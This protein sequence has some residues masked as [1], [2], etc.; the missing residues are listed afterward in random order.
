LKAGQIL[1]QFTAQDGKKVMLRTPKWE[2]LDDLLKVSNSLV[3]EEAEIEYDTQTTRNAEADWLANTLA[4]L[5]KDR[6]LSL[7][8]EVEGKVVASSSLIKSLLSS[9]KHLG[10]IGIII[11]AGYRNIGIGTEMMKMLI[12]PAKMRGLKI[13]TLSVFA[14]N[15]RAF[16]GYEKVGFK[17]AGRIRKGIYRKGRYI[18][19]IIM[20]K[21]LFEE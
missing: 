3:E 12:E 5:E 10:R 13:L 19:R 16:H 1:H 6:S 2:D 8:A 20:M 9:E 4:K 7:M 14:T 15:K 18:D 21:E 11:K 17:E